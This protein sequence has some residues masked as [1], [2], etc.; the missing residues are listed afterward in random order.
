MWTWTEHTTAVTPAGVE[1][2]CETRS[3]QDCRCLAIEE[4]ELCDVIVLTGEESES[5]AS[6]G[7]VEEYG[8]GMVP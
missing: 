8:G 6:A 7:V 5:L 2:A 4:A 3:I 1:D